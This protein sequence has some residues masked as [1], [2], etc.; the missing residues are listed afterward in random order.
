[1]G[2]KF[3]TSK[4]FYLLTSIFFAIIL[5]FNASSV[6]IRNQG[7]STAGEVYTS[8]I[9]N[10][11]IELK[12]NSDEYFVSGYNSM[13]NVYLTSY[14]RVQINNEENPDSRNFYLVVDLTNA[15][16]GTVTLPIRI[17]QLP[18]GVNAQI[19]PT[20]MTVRLEKKASQE[21]T[22]NPQINPNQI[23]EGFAVGSI[24]LS[25]E[26][27]KV[28]AGESSITQIH[29][30]EA[31]LPSDTLLNDDYSGT[32]TLHAVD[33]EG[34]ILP[35]QISPATVQMKVNV[36]KPSKTVPVE[37]KKQGSLDSSL[38]DM[39]T[40]SSQQTVTIYGEKAALDKIKNVTANVDITGVTQTKTVTVNL[41]VNGLS[42]KPS[43]VDITLTPVKK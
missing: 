36:D 25:Q 40:S 17:Q 8:T 22:I 26:T 31:T 29:S 12:Y 27:A 23:P 1:M 41:S 10:V 28:T 15:K 14:N 38:S 3:F 33:A 16:E 24:D 21:F 5:F 2:N 19:E 42:V 30:V 39:K 32:V 4:V 43:Q 11:P 13:A 7:I 37:V 9:N 20:T 18:N 35:A 6:A 34:K